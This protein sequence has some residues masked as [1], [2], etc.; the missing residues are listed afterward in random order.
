[1]A[2]VRIEQRLVEAAGKIGLQRRDVRRIH[3]SVTFR[4][5]GKALK[6]DAI[7]LRSDHKRAARDRSRIC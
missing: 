3:A 7:T 6:L 4:Q 5:A 2:L 1:M